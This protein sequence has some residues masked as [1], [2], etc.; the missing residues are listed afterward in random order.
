M[1]DTIGILWGPA[2]TALSTGILG[3]PLGPPS[4]L[5]LTIF[6]VPILDKSAPPALNT[7]IDFGA[8]QLIPGNT[9][10]PWAYLGPIQPDHNLLSRVA[11][12]KL[13]HEW[14]IRLAIDNGYQKVEQEVTRWT[15]ITT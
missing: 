15:G 6:T 2:G 3:Q 8:A 4:Q 5:D 11:Q 9:P 13:V 7:Q 1:L 12:A 10:S 14:L